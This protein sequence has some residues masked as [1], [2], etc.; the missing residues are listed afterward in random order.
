MLDA[1]VRCF[2]QL[3]PLNHNISATISRTGRLYA[4]DVLS[5]I[6]ALAASLSD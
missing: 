4:D 5:A 2:V 1:V 3:A 6:L